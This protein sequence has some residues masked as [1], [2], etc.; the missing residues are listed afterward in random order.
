M[1]LKNIYHIFNQINNRNKFA[2]TTDK[3]NG[4]MVSKCIFGKKHKLTLFFFFIYIIIC[5][6]IISFGEIL[7]FS[8]LF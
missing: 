4:H 5:Q 8:Y 7:G 1:L 6:A 3:H 2:V